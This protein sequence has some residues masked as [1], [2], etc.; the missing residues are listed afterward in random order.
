MNNDIAVKLW[1]WS[2]RIASYHVFYQDASGERWQLQATVGYRDAPQINLALKLQGYVWSRQW[3][4]NINRNR[5]KLADVPR[6][7]EVK[8]AVKE[9]H[10]LIMGD[11][12]HNP[13][14]VHVGAAKNRLEYARQELA[15]LIVFASTTWSG[16][17]T[18][19]EKIGALT[20]RE[21]NDLLSD[22]EALAQR[23]DE[24]YQEY[25]KLHGL[26]ADS[27]RTRTRAPA[28]STSA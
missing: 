20:T 25:D 26:L 11:S 14:G 2:W 16:S 24:A 4:R 15:R 27:R 17:M 10:T 3:S 5:I 22:I 9:R 8:K 28:R 6:Q 18:A 19:H 13:L 7:S 21:G 12:E 23:A 1:R